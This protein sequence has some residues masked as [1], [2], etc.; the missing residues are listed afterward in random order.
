[1]TQLERWRGGGYIPRTERHGQGQRRGM[2]SRYPPQTAEQ[3]VAL[4]RELPRSHS[5]DRAAL[6]LFYQ[7]YW[8]RNDVLQ[9]AIL[10]EMT[11]VRV[12]ME[13]YAGTRRSTRQPSPDPELTATRLAHRLASGRLSEETRRQTDLMLAHLGKALRWVRE[14]APQDNLETVYASLFHLFLSGDLLPGSEDVPYQAWVAYG[15]E[16]ALAG[17]LSAKTAVAVA[18]QVE[19]DE[20][21]REVLWRSSLPGLTKTVQEMETAD[22]ERARD[23]CA[24]VVDLVLFILRVLL[25]ALPPDLVAQLPWRVSKGVDWKLVAS[26]AAL[27]LVFDVRRKEADTFDAFLAIAREHLPQWRE[28]FEAALRAEVFDDEEKRDAI[29]AETIAGAQGALAAGKP[30]VDV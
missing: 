29:R 24:M 10:A 30:I 8:I 2:W 17:T 13:M 25:A 19:S 14:D 18:Q 26:V 20:V 5:L 21:V 12:Q 22:F 28:R 15:G 4:L 11:R 9:R 27:P 23:D 3:V 6:R 1:M 7:G 16:A